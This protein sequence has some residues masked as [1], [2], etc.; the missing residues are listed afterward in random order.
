MPN[1]FGKHYTRSEL[2]RRVGHISQVG[3]VQLLGSEDGPSRGVRYLEFRTGTGFNFKVAV[4][5]G[6][7]VGYAEYKGA[8][9]AWIP[10][11]MLPGP[12]YFE[13]QDHFGWLRTALGGLN[14]SCGMVHI[15]NPETA[16]VS[17]YNFPARSTETYGVHDRM[18]MLPGQLVSYGERWDG[19]EC[20]IE[21][22]GKVVQAQAY[23]ENLVLTRRYTA[24]LGE[25]RFFMHDEIENAGF[26]P[27]EHMLLYHINVGFPIVDE[28]SELVAPVSKPPA[29][30][31][32]L[33]ASDPNEYSRFV[34]PQKDWQLQGFELDMNAD[35]DGRVPVAVVNPRL[36]DG[37]QGLYVIY[38]QK[39]MPVYLEWR[40]MGEGQY[41]V[42]IEPCTNTF[43][44]DIARRAGQ[45]ITL[46]P[47]DRRVYD[48]EIGVLDGATAVQS[49]RDRV[50]GLVSRVVQR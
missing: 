42:G 33:P 40:M 12:W 14:N 28:G 34:G 9:L 26:L 20:I 22:V 2:M 37:G 39:Q 21:A 32:G 44:R 6:T 43:G 13:Q 3:G 38:N 17:R 10:P 24:R 18:A 35:S 30:P 8:S 31:D 5:R 15:G 7:D 41:A 16:D 25:S 11:T 45:L 27:A 48:I 29:I 36:G 50:K 47:G 23:G 19:D 49:F 4:E 46:Q 1:L